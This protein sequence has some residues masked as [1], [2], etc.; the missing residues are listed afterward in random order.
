MWLAV[1]II[2]TVIYERKDR[3]KP[4]AHAGRCASCRAQSSCR[5]F[6]A[7]TTDHI[8]CKRIIICSHWSLNP[9]RSIFLT[10]QT[11]LWLKIYFGVLTSRRNLFQWRDFITAPATSLMTS[12]RSI[13]RQQCF[14]FTPPCLYTSARYVTLSG[15]TSSLNNKRLYIIHQYNTSVWWNF[16]YLSKSYTVTPSV[17]RHTGAIKWY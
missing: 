17:L 6:D 15:R 4:L 2:M 9:L 10:V 12:L 16:W 11:L 1:I 5:K 7:Q 3:R 8:C 13:I 14:S